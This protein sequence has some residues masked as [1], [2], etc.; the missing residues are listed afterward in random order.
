LLLFCIPPSIRITMAPVSSVS[1]PLAKDTI[2]VVGSGGESR[3][4]GLH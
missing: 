2:V 4:A 1:G 3:K